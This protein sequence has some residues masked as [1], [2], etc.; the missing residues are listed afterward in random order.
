MAHCFVGLPKD[1]SNKIIKTYLFKEDRSSKV[2]QV[3][4]GD[5]LHVKQEMGDWLEIE[6]G[7]NSESPELLYIPKSHTS[8][9]RPLEIVFLDVGQGD[10]AVMISPERDDGEAVIVIDAGDSKNV[11]D[12]LVK[13]FKPYKKQFQFH[14][15]VLTHPDEDHYNGFSYIFSEDDF[16]FEVVY[17]NGL[18]ERPVRGTFEKVGGKSDKLSNNRAYVTDLAIHKSDIES[19]FSAGTDTGNFLF[20]QLMKAALANKNIKD[21]RIL[22]THHG[23]KEGSTAWMPGFAPSDGRDYCIE[24]L[25]PVIETIDD[26]KPKLRRIGSY[27]ETKNGHSILLRLHFGDFKILFGGDLNEK[28]EKFLLK[29]YTG[30][31]TFPRKG[32]D[33]YVDMINAASNSFA[34]EVMK[35]CHHGSE[36]VTDAFLEAVHPV[37]FVISSGDSEGHVHPRPDLLGRLGKK[38]RTRAPVILSTELQRSTREKEDKKLI[39]R[40]IR[41]IE[42]LEKAPTDFIKSKFKE[43]IELLGRSN[44]TVYGTIYLKTDGDTLITA[45][46]IETGGDKKKWFIFQ[47]EFDENQQLKLVS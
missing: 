45:F 6:W 12:F 29:H 37:A 16:G 7:P 26:G 19:L 2:R 43:E 24:V 4:W 13:R 20:P 23:T 17:H 14:A 5:W 25:G 46:R 28:A 42:G 38:G 34:A 10:G 18:V 11:H 22:S 9:T 39:D 3:L 47:Y 30:L 31:K 27:A 33:K 21:I 15:A 35:V 40:M 36:K 8:D 41:R 32:T 44:V 1:N